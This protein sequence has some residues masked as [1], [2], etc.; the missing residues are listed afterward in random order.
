MR[1]KAWVIGCHH[2]DLA[3]AHPDLAV[4]NA[5]GDALPHHLCP[6]QPEVQVYLAALLSDIAGQLDPYALELE[7]FD[8]PDA[9]EHGAHHEMCGVPLDRFHSF[10]LALCCCPACRG[11]AGARG[12][13][14]DRLADAVRAEILAHLRTPAWRLAERPPD[15]ARDRAAF[16]GAHAEFTPYLQ[17]RREVLQGLGARLRAAVRGV[18]GARLTPIGFGA[19]HGDTDLRQWADGLVTASTPEAVA[20]A[21][22]ALGPEADVVCGIYPMAPRPL[23]PERMAETLRACAQA[24]CT[25]FNYYN[26]ALMQ[27]STARDIRSAIAAW[28]R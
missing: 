15:A 11:A 16:A 22:L 7:S 2:T 10:L 19:F 25:G 27:E 24:G 28:G 20:A 6:G 12:V 4:Q 18:S 26:H 8:Y 1:L 3:L 14:A 9:F 13:D 5:L 17:A 21:R 23:S